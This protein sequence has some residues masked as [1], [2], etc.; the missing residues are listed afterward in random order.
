MYTQQILN[1]Y[2]DQVYGKQ[3]RSEICPENVLKIY[4]EIL[5]F[6]PKFWN[7][8]NFWLTMLVKDKQWN[9]FKKQ[10]HKT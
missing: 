10:W 2:F 7:L 3:F 8:W 1:E 6:F 5:N 4:L 9:Y